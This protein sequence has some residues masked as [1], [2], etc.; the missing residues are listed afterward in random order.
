[1]EGR[2]IKAIAVLSR[3]RSSSVPALASAHEQ[4]L[5]NF[6]ASTWLGFFLPKGTP[7][8]MVGRAAW[9]EVRSGA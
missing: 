1:M 4:G 3:D 2:T 7:A 5:V 8:W 9:N 6:D